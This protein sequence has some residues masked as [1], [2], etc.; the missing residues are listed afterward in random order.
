MMV[1]KLIA[2]GAIALLAL[3]GACAKQ[4][5]PVTKMHIAAV[6]QDAKASVF[7]QVEGGKPGFGPGDG[8]IE[9][10][11]AT[12]GGATTG[13]A[14]TTVTIT[15]GTKLDDATGVIDCHVQL[16]GGTVLFNGGFAFKD[17]GAGVDLPVVGGTGRYAGAGGSVK[18][19]APDMKHTNLTFDLL[20]PRTTA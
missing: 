5:A 12:V 10:S 4:E 3:A 8:L 20:I 7:E 2:A 19:Q 9:V 18:M 13:T 6:S 16:D 17:L 15:S 11:P 1:K 14:Y